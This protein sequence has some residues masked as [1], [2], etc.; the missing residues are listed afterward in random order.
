MA[1]PELLIGIRNVLL[2]QIVLILAA[3]RYALAVQ[4]ELLK[5][6]TSIKAPFLVRKETREKRNRFR[7]IDMTKFVP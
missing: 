5:I 3:P 4:R 6:W 1:L 2:V 7:E